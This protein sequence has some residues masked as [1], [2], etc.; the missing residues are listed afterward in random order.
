MLVLAALV[1]APVSYVAPGREVSILI[2][3]LLGL[4]L[5]RESH[6]RRRITGAAMI[7]AGIL[8]LALD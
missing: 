3:A 2:G 6:P 5:L 7:V 4:R 8:A 1:I